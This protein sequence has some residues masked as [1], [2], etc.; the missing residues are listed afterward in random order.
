MNYIAGV[1]IGNSTTEVCIAAL[2]NGRLH[3]L[4]SASKMTT[5]TKGTQANVAGILA[6]LKEA[7]EK[8]NMSAGDISLIRINEAAP[9]IGDTAME[10][11]TETIIT[12][13]SMIGHNPSTPAGAG[14]AVGRTISLGHLKQG[15]SYTPYIVMADKSHSYE[16]VADTLNRY[17]QA[18]NVT[19]MILQADEAVLVENRL[20]RKIPIVDEVRYIDKIPEGKLAALEVAMAGSGVRMLSNPYGI[21]TLLEL[22]AQE[23]KMVTPIAKSLIGKRSAVVIKTPHGNV[24]EQIL[25]AGEIYIEAE[26][27]QTV[28]IDAGADAIMRALSKAGDIRDIHGQEQTNVGNMLARIKK[29]MSTVSDENQEEIRITDLLAVDTL[30]PVV[31]S[32]ALAGETCLEK[33]VGIAAMVKTRQLPMEKIAD[34][35]RS[36]LKTKVKVA[37]VEAVMASLGAMTTPGTRLP[38]AILDLGGGS[39]DAAVMTSKGTVRMVHQAGAGELVTMLIQIELGLHSRNTAEQIKRY[40]LAKVESLF[41]MRL[42]SG[43][44]EFFPDAIEP[45]YF[46]S[47]VLLTG[48]DMI[49][50]DED[51]PMEKIVAVRREAKRKVFVTNAVRALQAVAP[52]QDLKNIPNVV[53]VGGSAED[54]EIP[55]MLMEKFAEYRIVCGRGN[56]RRTEGP[57]NAVA[58][59][60]VLS[61]LGD[62]HVDDE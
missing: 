60:L 58:T 12:E 20:E 47:V 56:I 41:H 26:K 37:G 9:V 16:E 13:S 38:L 34:E 52:E 1:D 40:P 51:I 21:A 43:A 4:G 19:G 7:C 27:D 18:R 23:T 30:A 50:I 46:G 44:I 10:T 28:N 32:G 11:I 29:G 39:T 31:I 22:D 25:P 3:F 14:Q 17:A 61:Y 57:R 45:K 5:G 48:K 36:Q 6:A 53:L 55:E 49:R 54:F 24:R 59:G 15:N 42:E 2:E 8:L 33:A 35:L 62:S